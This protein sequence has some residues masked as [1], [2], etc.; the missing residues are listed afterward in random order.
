MNADR[1]EFRISDADRQEALDAL[2][3]HVRTGRLGLEEFGER[4]AQVT[5][6]KTLGELAELFVDLPRPR[7]SVLD[8]PAQQPAPARQ[9]EVADSPGPVAS[10]LVSAAV[11]LSAVV[12]IV[13][14]FTVARGIFLVFLIPIAVALLVSA[15][16]GRG[17]P[18][19]R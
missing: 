16:T 10:W 3:E 17:W 6:A 14:Y 8:R 5:T 4:S 2:N 1:P 18:G 12:A 15:A 13:L 11:P 7:P 19:V 9:A